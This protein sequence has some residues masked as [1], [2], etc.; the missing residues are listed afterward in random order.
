MNRDPDAATA[1]PDKLLRLSEVRQCIAVS[2][3]TIYRL[4]ASAGFPRSYNI[5]AQV[6]RWRESEVTAWIQS[7]ARYSPAHAQSAQT[8][9]LGG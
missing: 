4:M 9:S 6:R 3:A 7:R 1:P 2:S 8:G 5:G